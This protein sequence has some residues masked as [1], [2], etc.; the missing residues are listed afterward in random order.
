MFFNIQ[1]EIGTLKSVLLHKPGK[2]LERLTP[3]YLHSYLFDDIPWLRK[4]KEEHDEF[5]DLL[6]STGAEVFYL[7][8]MLKE[9]LADK[10]IKS[11]F[12]RDLLNNCKHIY[13]TSLFHILYDFIYSKT[14]QEIA[15]IAT[16][17]LD[18]SDVEIPK[19]QLHLAGFIYKDY[20]LYIDPLPNLYFTRDFSS[21][22]ANGISLN[23]MHTV[24]RR[25]ETL[26]IKY[27]YENHPLIKPHNHPLW[28]GPHIQHSIEGGDILV[29]SDEV[30]A[31]GC[32]ERTSPEGIESLTRNLFKSNDTI[33]EVLAIYI[34]HLRAFMHLDTV[35][36]MIDRDKFIIYPGIED[37]LQVFSITRGS[38]GKINI[39]IRSSLIDSLRSSLKI[40]VLNLLQSG[41][42]N[43]ITAAREQWN[44]STNTFA[45]SEGV[46]ITYTRN[47]SSNEVLE[48]NGIKVLQINGSELVRGRGGPRCM[49][50]PMF[51]ENLK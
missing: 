45:V 50:M 7:E 25:R 27:I 49:T 9:V 26:L 38:N 47:E 23:T 18:K 1:S 42:G 34:P 15:E 30:V 8:T 24:A 3:D 48:K 10:E 12:V 5:A 20:P 51:R 17:G 29:L 46:V 19:D 4:I 35:F 13:N 22:I 40:P 44:D 31:I 39:A 33:K 41:G 37:K 28:Y 6:R 16:G 43:S 32:S 14:P 2:E 11:N 21:V 36:T